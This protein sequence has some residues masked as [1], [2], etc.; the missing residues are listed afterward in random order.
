MTTAAI[1]APQAAESFSLPR[2]RLPRH[3]AIIMDGNGRWAARQGLPRVLGHRA[4]VR[5]VR[6]IVAEAARLEIEA[7]TLYSFSSENWKRPAEEVNGLMELCREHLVAQRE[8]LMA[9]GVRFR[10]IGR[11][12]GLPESVRRELSETE[13]ATRHGSKTT[14][15]LA[16]NYGA[17]AELVDAMRAIARAVAAGTLRPDAI[18]EAV[19]DRNLYTAGL[20]DP[21]LL[22]RTAGELRLSNYLLWQISYAE[23]HVTDVLWPD[24]SVTDLH[25]ALSDFAGRRRRFGGLDQAPPKP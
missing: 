1:H 8:E 19:I 6:E 11:L 23:I 7:I 10:A 9:N 20:P 21:D 3:V 14:M 17:R 24:F 4:G 18:D 22:I 15:V 12:D 2:E 13:T 25:L 5:T 16:L